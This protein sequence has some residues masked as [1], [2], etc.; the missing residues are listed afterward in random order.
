M[1]MGCRFVSSHFF[2][3]RPQRHTN[4]IATL[5]QARAVHS[6][7]SDLNIEHTIPFFLHL[8]CCYSYNPMSYFISRISCMASSLCTRKETPAW[9]LIK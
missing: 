4:D 7:G 6:W 1:K 5:P 9:L 8:Q 3:L 2:F